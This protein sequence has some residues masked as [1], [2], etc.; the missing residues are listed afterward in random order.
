MPYAD[1]KKQAAAVAASHAKSN[2]ALLTLRVSEETK[3][4]WQAAVKDSGLSAGKYLKL[5][6]EKSNEIRRHEV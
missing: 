6:L 3:R 2:T 1:P 5:L 4:R